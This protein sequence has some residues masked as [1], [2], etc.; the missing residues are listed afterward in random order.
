MATIPPVAI[1][2]TF[3]QTC[4]RG[5]NMNNRALALTLMALVLLA[6][7]A[8]AAFPPWAQ[9]QSLCDIL[10]LTTGGIPEADLNGDGLTCEFT[11]VDAVTGV[12]TT[13]AVDNVAVVGP[14]DCPD[15]FTG[16]LSTGLCCKFAP[17][18]LPTNPVPRLPDRLH[19]GGRTEEKVRRVGPDQNT[20]GVEPPL[21][22]R[23]VSCESSF[24]R[25]EKVGSNS[26]ACFQ[27]QIGKEP[28]EDT[29]AESSA[30]SWTDSA[31]VRPWS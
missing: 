14:S 6:A 22:A 29:C 28:R 18:Q 4:R 9:A 21:G 16:S 19:W 17:P 7:A 27:P 26:S 2:G 11:T 25:V 20:M 8:F 13:I 3:N 12:S 1:H 10:P 5:E 31:Q 15:G 24:G 30:L 23:V